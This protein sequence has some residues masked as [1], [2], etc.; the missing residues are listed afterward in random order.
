MADFPLIHTSLSQLISLFSIT[1]LAKTSRSPLSPAA[2][3]SLALVRLR[4][5]LWVGVQLLSCSARVVRAGRN[6]GRVSRRNWHLRGR[7]YS[8]KI[9]LCKFDWGKSRLYLCFS[10]AA[11]RLFKY[12]TENTARCT[13]NTT[14]YTEY[15]NR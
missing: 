2:A 12:A 7:L 10:V 1:T 13:K 8:L 4:P 9:G 6:G 15:C 5:S 11:S 3:L 14:F